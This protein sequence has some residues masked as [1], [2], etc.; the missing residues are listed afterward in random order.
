MP[1]RFSLAEPGIELKLSEEPG[2]NQYL[3]FTLWTKK[4]QI[5][6]LPGILLE[7][8][9]ECKAKNKFRTCKPFQNKAPAC[10]SQAYIPTLFCHL[11]F[12]RRFLVGSVTLHSPHLY[13]FACVFACFWKARLSTVENSHL[14]QCSFE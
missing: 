11:C 2:A 10:N 12:S 1:P 7:I 8:A 14:L 5:K 3:S 4:S 13:I 6:P 9:G